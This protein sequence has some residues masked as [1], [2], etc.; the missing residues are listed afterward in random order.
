M[1]SYSISGVNPYLSTLSVTSEKSLGF[2][3]IIFQELAYIGGSKCF[4]WLSKLKILAELGG[5]RKV[6]ISFITLNLLSSAV[7]CCSVV[8]NSLRPSM[9]CSPPCYSVHGDSPG[10]NTRVGCH[11]LLQGNFLTQGSN[12]GLL[13]RRQILYHLSHQGSPR[14]LE[15][16]ALFFSRGSSQP[17]DIT[18][19]SHI[20]GR[21]FTSWATREAQEYWSG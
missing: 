11:A 17:R 18:Q 20:A 6:R 5:G 19:V 7:L 2:L 14:I 1:L 10:K 4:L 8:S 12:P 21:F 9:D 16:I 3:E 13:H 15:W